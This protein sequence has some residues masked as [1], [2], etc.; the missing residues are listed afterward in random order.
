MRLNEKDT[1]CGD[2]YFLYS[3]KILSLRKLILPV[4]LSF[5]IIFLI[6]KNWILFRF[7]VSVILRHL[8]TGHFYWEESFLHGNKHVEPYGPPAPVYETH[9]CTKCALHGQIEPLLLSEL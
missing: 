2:F 9:K 3:E 8:Q 4:P 7:N 5:F 6:A 1:L